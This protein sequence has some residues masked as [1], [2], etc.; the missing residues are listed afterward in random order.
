MRCAI[1]CSTVTLAALALGMLFTPSARS[2]DFDAQDV[3]E[4]RFIL[5]AAS[6]SWDDHQFLILE[7]ISDEQACW[8]ESGEAPT[9]VNP[10]LL[11]FDF[12][13]ICGR[14][15]DS[16]GYSLRVE[17]RDLALDYSLRVIRR[18]ND[19]RLVASS[20]TDFSGAPIE[21]GRSYGISPQGYSKIVLDPGWR[22][23]RRTFEGTLLGHIYIT[24]D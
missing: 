16:N 3:D 2:V 13:G 14:S 20:N 5:V 24:S 15:I 19:L 9:T 10:L 6:R 7:Q 21:I 1:S 18:G 8:A 17:D 11:N 12:T 22:L 4:S 23:A